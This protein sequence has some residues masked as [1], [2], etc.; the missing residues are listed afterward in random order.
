MP[1]DAT[2]EEREISNEKTK[3]WNARPGRGLVFFDGIE[4][5]KHVTKERWVAFDDY[6]P[7]SWENEI[8]ETALENQAKQVGLLPDNDPG[9]N[10]DYSWP[11]GVDS[12]NRAINQRPQVASSPQLATCGRNCWKMDTPLRSSKGTWLIRMRSCRKCGRK[13]L[14]VTYIT[15]DFYQQLASDRENYD[16]YKIA[17][18]QGFNQKTFWDSES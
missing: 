1:A 14:P 8:Y 18:E 9:S 7:Q 12:D 5:G 6:P 4:N 11:D 15:D 2:D 13:V 3:A 16:S 17:T 10:S